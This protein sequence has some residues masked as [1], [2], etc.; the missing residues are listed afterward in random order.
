MILGIFKSPRNILESAVRERRVWT[1]A[2]VVALWALLNLVLTMFFVFG[3]GLRGQLAGLPPQT[4][5]QLLL[6]LKVLVP[7][8]AFVL[9]F[10]W[11][12]G[13]SAPMLLATRLFGGRADYPSMLAVVG[14]AC[15]PWVAGYAIQLPIGVLQLFLAGQS[16]ILAVL[17][18]LAFAVSAA[19]LAWHAA[20][21]VIGGRIAA[22]I[23]Y[24]G[25]G[26]SCALTGLGCATAGFILVVTVLTLIFGLSGAM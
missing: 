23:S 17:G 9:P 7:I 10:V 1:A 24:R 13:I 19:S 25:S 4:L 20:L 11:W 8:S 18:T 12:I 14:A 15:V 21:V 5:D 16:G 6:T 26:G 22:G 2:G 3:G